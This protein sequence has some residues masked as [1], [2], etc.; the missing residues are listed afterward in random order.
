MA[1]SLRDP[2]S[3][4][5]FRRVWRAGEQR[6][7]AALPTAPTQVR[8]DNSTSDRYTIVDVFAADR[9]GLL[10]TIARSLF[11]SGLSVAVAKIGTYLDQAVDV[12]Y[13]ND[14]AGRKITDEDRL[15]E[16]VRQL[17]ADL[18]EFE[19]AEAKRSGGS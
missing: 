13:V 10:Y 15:G 1:S 17:S 3:K 12:F 9:M 8:I 5:T 11:R 4:P 16:I 19:I 14:D 2:A 6:R 7:Q 18:E